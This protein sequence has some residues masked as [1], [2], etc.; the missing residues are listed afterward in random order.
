MIV[1]DSEITS[2]D[3]AASSASPATRIPMKYTAHKDLPCETCGEIVKKG[4]LCRIVDGAATDPGD[5]K[6]EHASHSEAASP[7][8]DREP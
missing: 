8:T 6:V 5:W 3:L 4:T 1:A 7:A 2:G